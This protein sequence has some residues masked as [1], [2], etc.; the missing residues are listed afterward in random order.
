MIGPGLESFTAMAVHAEVTGDEVKVHRVDCA[1]DCGLVLNPDIA[2]AQMEGAVIMGRGLALREE[3]KFRDGAV[4]TSNFH[5]YGIL[6]LPE[7]PPEIHI[8]FIGLEQRPT[9]LGEPGV[10]TFAPALANAIH[11]A[12]GKRHRALPLQPGR[13]A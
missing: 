7:A 13:A 1:V 2:R 6:R 10:P 5:D 8:E 11:A 9:G 3:V 4:V 12:S